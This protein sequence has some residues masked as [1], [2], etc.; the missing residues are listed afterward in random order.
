MGRTIDMELFEIVEKAQEDYNIPIGTYIYEKNGENDRFIS[1]VND[2]IT[3]EFRNKIS[4]EK[5]KRETYVSIPK[6]VWDLK[7]EDKYYYINCYGE[8]DSTF[9]D[10]DEDVDII[11]CGNAFLKDILKMMMCLIYWK[12][13]KIYEVEWWINIKKHG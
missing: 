7:E 2:K 5:E 8:I 11:K 1:K 3:I 12:K 4:W 9:Y 10:C 6:T 13:L